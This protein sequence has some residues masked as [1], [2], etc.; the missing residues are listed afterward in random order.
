MSRTTK[1]HSETVQTDWNI[2]RK[3]RLERLTSAPIDRCDQE[4]NSVGR[5]KLLLLR[6]AIVIRHSEV[7]DVSVPFVSNW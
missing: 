5:L 3:I 6:P 7:K 1:H 2:R 4:I